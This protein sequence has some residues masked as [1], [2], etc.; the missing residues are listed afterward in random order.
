MR[1]IAFAVAAAFALA[2]AQ[3]KPA[4]SF[5]AILACVKARS[6]KNMTASTVNWFDVVTIPVVTFSDEG[7]PSR[8]A[9]RAT[10]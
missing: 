5:D 2:L 7:R 10:P 9:C 1:G 8:L 4:A 6:C 3:D